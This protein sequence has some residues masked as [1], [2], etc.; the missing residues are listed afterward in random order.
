VQNIFQW[1][2]YARI[3]VS[4]LFFYL[5]G[6]NLNIYSVVAI[7]I[8]L[9]A[10]SGFCPLYKV[11]G[12]NKKYAKKL[13]YLSELP[14]SNPEPT[15]IFDDSGK[16]IYQNKSSKSILPNIKDFSTLSKKTPQKVIN[17]EDMDSIKF[18]QG[19]NT[20]LLRTK[21]SKE[22]KVIFTYG[23]NITELENYTKT[24]E[25]I[26]ITDALSGL[27]NRKNMID[28][29][30]I[31]KNDNL[32][33]FIIDIKQF[34]GINNFFGYTKAD[35]FLIEFSKKLNSFKDKNLNNSSVYRLQANTFALLINTNNAIKNELDSEV[36][37]IKTELFEYFSDAMINIE[38]IDINF[39]IRVGVA[40]K[41]DCDLD[42][43]I[44]TQL[45]N[46]AEI[47]LSIAKKENKKFQKFEDIS[48]I[49]D[50]YREN[51]QWAKKLKEIFA[52][53]SDAKIVSYFQPIYNL[54]TKKIEKFE[55]L[56][57]I[58]DKGEVIS[59]FKFLDVARQVNLL[60][61]ITKEMLLQSMEKF[62]QS[63]FE[64]SINISYQD[65]REK[66]L[67]SFFTNTIKQYKFP[68]NKVVIEILE[69]EN[70]YEFTDVIIDL[71]KE[72]F[73]IAI[74]DFGT[75][76]S[77][78]Q[79]LQKLNADYLKIDASLIK[80]IAKSPK[81]LSIVKTICTYAKTIGVK[82][83]AE[84][85][86]NKDIF[87]LVRQ[88]GIDYAQGYYISAPNPSIKVEFNGK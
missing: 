79:K 71:K 69:D 30:Q 83:I 77:N 63:D 52:Q 53:K 57:R 40:S 87:D 44:P 72:G 13:E 1:G 86:A 6:A 2:R 45:L 56:V 14:N 55:T 25:I 3:F 85:V 8:L 18:K 38:N 9:T 34:S 26:N 66:D 27:G 42:E 78:F 23:F 50:E 10:L 37:Q 11:M 74:D 21:G 49:L 35:N 67:I 82:T 36:K 22:K 80:N 47:A 15:F 29:I 7:I 4:L 51:F 60:P 48:Y 33:I 76:Y 54:K 73:K 16:I 41:C 39:D 62:K 31:H 28:D 64:F 84:F 61:D 68:A 70:M 65:L 75:G 43:N 24:L 17:E 5:A 59:P 19:E 32:S 88:C 20:Y 12:V 46:K 58:E 81:D